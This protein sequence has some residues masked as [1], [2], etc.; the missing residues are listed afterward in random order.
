MAG[1]SVYTSLCRRQVR[2]SLRRNGSG[3][4]ADTGC[5]NVVR[6][7]VQAVH[8]LKKSRICRPARLIKVFFRLPLA[9]LA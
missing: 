3:S 2:R 1:S 4:G 7:V 5:R 6:D 8:P 9:Y